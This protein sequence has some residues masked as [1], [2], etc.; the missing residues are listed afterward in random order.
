MKNFE[1]VVTAAREEVSGVTPRHRR[2][3]EIIGSQ[4]AAG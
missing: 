4:N 3:W 2:K 1:K